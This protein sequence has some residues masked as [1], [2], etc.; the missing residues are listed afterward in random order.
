MKKFWNLIL[1]LAVI[2]GVSSC[3]DS[4]VDGSISNNFSF[5]ATIEHTRADMVN[6]DGTWQTIWSGDDKLYVTSDKGSF[7]FANSTKEPHRFV[8]TDAEASVLRDATNI[9]ITTLH[10]NG[11]VVDS[12]AGKRGLSLSMDYERF[13]KSGEVSLAVRSSPPAAAA[14]TAV[15]P[16]DPADFLPE[17]EDRCD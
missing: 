5:V 1:A 13:P 8:S 14:H 9:V 6:S 3:S 10:E 4:D 2:M 12:D 16:I 15:L 17:A 11:S 7:T